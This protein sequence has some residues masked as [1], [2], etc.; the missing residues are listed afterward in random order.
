[1]LRGP[2]PR[3]QPRNRHWYCQGRARLLLQSTHNN[4]LDANMTGT[5][6]PQSTQI[7]VGTSEVN[8]YACTA[9]GLGSRADGQRAAVGL[10]VLGLLV[11]GVELKQP[12]HNL[13]A[14]RPGHRK[15]LGHAGFFCKSTTHR[16]PHAL[17]AEYEW[18]QNPDMAMRFFVPFFFGFVMVFRVRDSNI[19]PNKDLHWS[20]QVAEQLDEL[21]ILNGKV[22]PQTLYQ[23][24]T[25]SLVSKQ[26][27]KIVYQLSLNPKPT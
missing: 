8:A 3:L 13:C 25:P 4:G 11:L 21:Q 18:D 19:I 20:L 12:A 15:L 23:S 9:L 14:P 10:G 22:K 26:I 27:S 1:M 16:T 7:I 2:L 5:W 24:Q 17:L 6:A